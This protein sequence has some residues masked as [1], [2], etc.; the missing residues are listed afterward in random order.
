MMTS[1]GRRFPCLSHAS[2]PYCSVMA[3]R[4][5]IHDQK[6]SVFTTKN[7]SVKADP[8]VTRRDLAAGEENFWR[9]SR[10]TPKTDSRPPVTPRFQIVALRND[11]LL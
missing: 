10:H 6:Y 8:A 11:Y 7:R 5:C 2:R 3:L 1:H 4:F 9:S